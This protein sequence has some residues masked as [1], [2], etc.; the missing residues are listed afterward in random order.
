MVSLLLAHQTTT[1]AYVKRIDANHFDSFWIWGNISSAN[2]LKKAQELYIL[3]GEFRLNSNSKNSELQPQ[4]V[5]ILNIP[6]Q[7]VWLVYRNHHLNWDDR[8]IKLI[9]N[10]IKQWENRGNHIV[11]IQIDFDA[12]TKHLAQYG[13]FL[14]KLRKKL[15]KHYQLSIT[16]LLDWTN[17]TDTHTLNL[18][19]ENID[20]LV[21]QTYQVSTTIPHYRNY[22]RKISQLN[23]PYKIGY[24]QHGIWDGKFQNNDPLFKGN[25]IFLLR[26]Q[27]HH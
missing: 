3:Q 11:G 1:F 17:V 22:L 14:E 9:L 21:I 24:V 8:E 20:E 12:K 7:K 19:R 27:D 26:S 23:L 5:S 6:H 18:L 25:V 13:L 10:R 16:G 15:P 2:Y 4:G